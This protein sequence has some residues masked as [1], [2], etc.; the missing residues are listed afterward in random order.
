[1]STSP[2]RECTENGKPGFSCG[3]LKCFTYS[4][5]AEKNE[6]R[7]KA[8]NQCLAI[9]EK[10]ED[11][12]KSG[13]TVGEIMKAA[14]REVSSIKVSQKIKKQLEEIL[15]QILKAG[16]DDDK[17]QQMEQITGQEGQKLSNERAELRDADENNRFERCQFCQHFVPETTCE[18][19]VGPVGP[20]MVCNWI[21][22]SKRAD[23]IELLTVQ[24]E[25]LLA[26]GMGLMQTQPLGIE[27]KDAA[28]T[29]DG[30]II[31]LE[32]DL[33]HDYSLLKDDFIQIISVLLHWTQ[34]EVNTIIQAGKEI[35]NQIQQQAKME[36]AVQRF[37]DLPLAP[38]E[39]EWDGD[40]AEGRVREWATENGEVDFEK[41]ARAFFWWDSENPENFTSYKLGYADF[42]DGRLRAVPR[43]I[44]AVAAVLQGARG[45]TTIPQAD[46]ERIRGVVSRYYAKMRQEF[47]DDSIVP[48]WEVRGASSDGRIDKVIKV[49]FIAK[50]EDKR[51]V[52]GIVLEPDTEDAHG[53]LISSE[54]IEKAAHFFMQ[55]SR[56]I[57]ESH[58]KAA[59]A[60]VVESFIAPEELTMGDQKIKKGSWVLGIKVLDDALWESVKSGEFTGLSVGGFGIR[61]EV[62]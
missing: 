26:F 51:L 11:L 37:L 40:A 30:F 4:T 45:G 20:N 24:D 12:F 16:P 8:I 61:E 49:D 59:E 58:I 46:Q 53:D 38:R 1:M 32:D 5:N 36:K 56:T 27:I 10:P 23:D 62:A 14:A 6:S 52:F 47:E 22:S 2:V 19:V 25:D 3:D 17:K 13:I 42:I 57:G 50:E 18:I 33:G 54:E 55:K 34:D 43:G 44:F 31:Q 28:I 48:P 41:Y 7:Q 29:P 9:G 15:S 35:M 60:Q 39:R 21:Q